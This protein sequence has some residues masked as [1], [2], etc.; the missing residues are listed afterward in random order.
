MADHSS[1]TAAFAR[2]NIIIMSDDKNGVMVNEESK[3]KAEEV[4][5]IVESAEC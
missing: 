5:E 1:F 2:Y 4:Y 3:V